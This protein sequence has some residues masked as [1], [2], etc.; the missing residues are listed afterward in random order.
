MGWDLG[1]QGREAQRTAATDPSPTYDILDKRGSGHLCLGHQK[2]STPRGAG[3]VWLCGAP[4]G[5]ATHEP[6]CALERATK[7]T[8][9]GGVVKPCACLIDIR[10]HTGPRLCGWASG[11]LQGGVVIVKPV[12]CGTVPSSVSAGAVQLGRWFRI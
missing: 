11:L 5:G 9:G 10:L 6:A 4:L 12:R 7:T 8:S 3:S 2:S 1:T